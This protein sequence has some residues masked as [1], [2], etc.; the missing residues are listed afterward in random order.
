MELKQQKKEAIWRN[1]CSDL[2]TNVKS[3]YESD[4]PIGYE[5]DLSCLS[6]MKSN[7][8]PIRY[9]IRLYM[10]CWEGPYLEEGTT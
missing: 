6:D 1:I 7:Y 8:V 2:P 3:D 4:L 9:H 5:T 10:V